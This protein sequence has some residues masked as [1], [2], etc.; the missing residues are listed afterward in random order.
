VNAEPDRSQDSGHAAVSDHLRAC[1]QGSAER[2]CLPTSPQ[3]ESRRDAALEMHQLP[4][5]AHCGDVIGVYEPLV[6]PVGRDVLQTS[7]AA[8]P[9]LPS[10]GEYYHGDCYPERQADSSS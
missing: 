2:G 1:G 3:A 10:H 4:R 7:Y 6:M 8:Q 5:C 9:D